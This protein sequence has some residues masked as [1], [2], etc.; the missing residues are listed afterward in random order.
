MH[1]DCSSRCGGGGCCGGSVS[2]SVNN[3]PPHTLEMHPPV[4]A[5]SGLGGRWDELVLLLLLLQV[6]LVRVRTKSV[7]IARLANLSVHQHLGRH[8]SERAL[9][10]LGTQPARVTASQ[11]A[12]QKAC[13][14]A[15]QLPLVQEAPPH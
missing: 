12:S 9:R 11:P 14:A 7:H 8:V 13:R 6:L 15:C 1:S 3:K 10:C 2:R 5:G 4:V